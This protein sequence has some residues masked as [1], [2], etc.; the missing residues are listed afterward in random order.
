MYIQSKH[1]LQS[2]AKTTKLVNTVHGCRGTALADCNA[3]IIGAERTNGSVEST[4][5][6]GCE[7]LSDL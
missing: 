4:L 6:V 3:V 2:K 1:A 7:T 5:D